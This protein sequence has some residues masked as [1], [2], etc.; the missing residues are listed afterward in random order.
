MPPADPVTDLAAAAPLPRPEPGHEGYF[1]AGGGIDRAAARRADPAALARMRAAPDAGALVFEAG[2]IACGPS[3]RPVW[4]RP[5]PEALFL[6]LVRGAPRFAQ[7]ASAPPEGTEFID[8]RAAFPNLDPA[9]AELLATARALLN[10]HRTHGFC[11]ACGARSQMTAAGW[12]RLCPACDT[13]HFPRTDPVVIMLITRGNDTLLGRSPHFPPGMYSCL[14][15]FVEPGET[16]EAAVAREVAE[17]TGIKVGAVRYLA[18][19]PWPFP[20]SLML[21]AVGLAQPG[22]IRLDP[23]ELEDALWLSREETVTLLAGR[24]ATMTAPRPGAIARHLL[25]LWLADRVR[26]GQDRRRTR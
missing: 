16:L 10:W 1:A 19:Q 12:E 6:G 21:A 22:P 4:Q 24:H 5:D 9:E 13:R 3:G 18:S 8:A 23:A 15:G 26:S 20:N 11:A 17:E 25:E 14:A 7:T 2:R